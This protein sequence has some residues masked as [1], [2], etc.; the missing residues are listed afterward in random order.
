MD[1]QFLKQDSDTENPGVRI[2][3][4]AR[5]P[6]NALSIEMS[7]ELD[8][9]FRGFHAD[10]GLRCVILTG[11]GER[12]FSAGADV[13][14]I[15]RRTT[16]IAIER[17]VVF[18]STFDAIRQCPVPTIAAVNGLAIGA[19]L[20]IAS[21]CDIVLAEESV[22]F[23]LPEVLIGVMGGA[24]H[25]TRF[26]SDKLVRYLA[27]TGERISARELKSLGEVREVLPRSALMPRAKAIARG[28]ASRSPSS[29]RLMKEA[30][31]LTED[32]SLNDGYRVEQLFTTLATSLPDAR[33][34]SLA[35]IE[36]RP[37][38]FALQVQDGNVAGGGVKAGT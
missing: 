22:E 2:V 6:V 10:R 20:V 19:G 35:F 9:L 1:Y 13:K 16:E 17:S 36:K 32:M 29:V 33:E 3:T 4:M 8:R 18:R 15:S 25:A 24:R 21:C 7:R 38:N 14:E 28:I 31:N 34:A 12:L 5:P 37:P 26:M 27:F 11:E 30:I 23:S